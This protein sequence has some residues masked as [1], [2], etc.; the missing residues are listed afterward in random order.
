MSTRVSHE[1]LPL[2]VED[3]WQPAF[4]A[5]LEAETERSMDELAKR[6]EQGQTLL[7]EISLVSSDSL[8][9][10]M[11]TLQAAFLAGMEYERRKLQ[12]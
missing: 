6:F 4:K 10:G 12:H 1:A 8:P 2:Q 7:P 5:W 3:D 11:V 9:T